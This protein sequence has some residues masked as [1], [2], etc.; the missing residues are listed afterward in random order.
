MK[1]QLYIRVD[2]NAQIGFGHFSRTVSL[3]FMLSDIFDIIFVSQFIPE[4]ILN[5]IQHQNWQYLSISSETSF[6]DRLRSENIVVLDGYNFDTEYQK[7]IKSKACKLICIDDLHAHPFLADVIINSS[8]G[9]T[10]KDYQCAP[11]TKLCLG[12]DYILL[13]PLFLEQAKQLRIIGQKSTLF[14]CFGGSDIGEFTWKIL[15]NVLEQNQCVQKIN[16]VITHTNPK[17]NEIEKLAKTTTNKDVFVFNTLSEQEIL[18]VMLD[19]NIA[20]VPSS[21]ILFEVLCVKMPV[22]SGYYVDNQRSIYQGVSSLGLIQGL[23]NLYECYNFGELLDQLTLEQSNHMIQ[24][25]KQFI[26]GS[27]SDHIKSCFK[28]LLK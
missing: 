14:I 16:V 25:Q 23:G 1:T 12:L 2:G 19:S 9:S 7:I 8:P 4:H 20:I 15:N 13:R 26:T 21:N 5:S 27:S 18:N 6:F 17:R 22:L 11:N 24:I 10:K 28:V 3:A